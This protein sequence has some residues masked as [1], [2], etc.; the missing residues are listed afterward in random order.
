MTRRPRV[1]RGRPLSTLA[2][3]EL[4]ELVAAEVRR[5]VEE[6]VS[7]AGDRLDG[8]LGELREQVAELDRRLTEVHERALR[9]LTDQ[10]K[11][12]GTT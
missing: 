10:I 5:Q 8:E 3:S 7:S 6:L 9:A 11:R 1:I 12:R 2:E 4:R